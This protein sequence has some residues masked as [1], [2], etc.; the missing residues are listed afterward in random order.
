[1][2]KG[3]T[4]AYVQFKAKS[5]E[6]AHHHTFGYDLVVIKGK[7]KVWNLTKKESYKL[8]DWDFLFTLGR[9]VHKVKYLEDAEF[10][11]RWGF[12]GYL[13]H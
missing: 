12:G 7:K 3:T 2:R 4:S 8:E 5:M 10:F 13:I 1:M 9:N 6:L 11:I